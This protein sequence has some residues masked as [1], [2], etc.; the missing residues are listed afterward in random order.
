MRGRQI[1]L[2]LCKVIDVSNV[3]ILFFN[4][5][6]LFFFL[7]QVTFGSLDVEQFVRLNLVMWLTTAIKCMC[8]CECVRA[9]VSPRMCVCVRVCMCIPGCCEAFHRGLQQGQLL[10]SARP[11]D[12]ENKQQQK[13]THV[14]NS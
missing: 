11:P 10:S 3:C 4:V 13:D 6:I 7:T 9:C 1:D 5:C 2:V 8:V 12:R 14:N